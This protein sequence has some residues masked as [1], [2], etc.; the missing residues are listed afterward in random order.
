[1]F[2]WNYIKTKHPKTIKLGLLV[3]VLIALTI[4]CFIISANNDPKSKFYI[5]IQRHFI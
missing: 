5:K 3:F 4:L 2:N 1:M